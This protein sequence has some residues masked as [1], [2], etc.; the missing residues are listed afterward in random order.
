MDRLHRAVLER[1]GVELRGFQ[2][3]AVVP[4][5]NRVLADHLGS[6]EL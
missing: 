2:R 5:T 1:L 6:P 3:S 4:E